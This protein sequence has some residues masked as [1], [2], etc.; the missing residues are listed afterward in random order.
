MPNHKY[1]LEESWMI[2][3]LRKPNTYRHPIY[4]LLMI[5]FL[6]V[7]AQNFW[8]TPTD[9]N[10]FGKSPWVCLN[11]AAKHYRKRVITSFKLGNR[12][13]K[14]QPVGIFKCE[15]G[16]EYARSGPDNNR[17]D[18]FR[19]DKIINFGNVWESEL[20]RLWNESGKSIT[21]ISR[22]LNVDPVTV[23][24]YATKL[25]LSF[26]RIGK[27]YQQLAESNK[28]KTTPHI[29]K[30]KSK[31]KN[32]NRENKSKYAGYIDWEKRDINLSILVKEAAERIRNS[33]ERP[34]S[35]TKTS[36]G[37]EANC[38]ALLLTKL[39]KLPKT[40]ETLSSIVDSDITLAI[41]RINWV[42]NDFRQKGVHIKKWQLI[43]VA[44]VFRYR[45][46]PI[47]KDTIES[48]IHCFQEDD[49]NQ[50]LLA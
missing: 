24:R 5:N 44:C 6:G 16:F 48:A 41:R 2:R 1:N 13:R 10:L 49:L 30:L 20:V 29:V 27:R 34:R 31:S 15:C 22:C 12:I 43:E 21:E 50:R 23:R 28:L 4:H 40:A 7:K 19:I 26:E 42:A 8:E 17:D 35:V 39:H 18:K 33:P 47:I 38:L 46:I 36:I 37:R 45:H 11:A 3:L 25:N 32:L 9:L 14:G